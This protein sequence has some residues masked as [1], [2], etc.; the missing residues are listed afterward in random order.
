MEQLTAKL[1][2]SG[3][4]SYRGTAWLCSGQYALTAAHCVGDRER[5]V[6]DAGPFRLMFMNGEEVAA[7]LMEDN[8]DFNLDVAMLRITHGTLPDNVEI[9]CGRLPA[10]TPWPPRS[11]TW[12]AY[13]YPV[14]NESGMEL[15]GFI[16][17]PNGNVEG[18]PA[19]QLLC[20]QG[21]Y[22]ELEGT[23]GAA[24]R[25]GKIVVG[26]IRWAPTAFKQS[27]IYASPLHIIAEKL[28]V[29][30]NILAVNFKA[31]LAQLAPNLLSPR[32]INDTSA[33][34][35]IKRELIGRNTPHAAGASSHN[36][37]EQKT[38]FINRKELDEVTK[39]LSL[40]DVQLLTLVGLGGTG[41]TRLALEAG[42]ALV[43]HN[44]F[45]DGIFLVDMATVKDP[46][47]VAREIAN[48]LGIKEA[49][50]LSFVESLKLYLGDKQMLLIIDNFEQVLPAAPLF[51]ELLSVCKEL[52]VL[53]T[54]QQPLGVNGEEVLQIGPLVLP[55]EPPQGLSWQDLKEVA[56]VKLFEKRAQ[57][58]NKKFKL[59][60]QN[61]PLIAGI[62]RA[63]GGLPMAIE[64]VAA[65]AGAQVDLQKA[66]E[67]V[68]AATKGDAL[69]QT[70]KAVEFAYGKL[71]TEEQTLLRRLSLFVGSFNRMTA[72]HVFRDVIDS[73]EAVKQI[74][75]SL[76]RKCLLQEEWS[77]NQKVSYR[78]LQKI[79]D[80]CLNQLEASGEAA[81]ALRNHAR[82]FL[83]RA[84]RAEARMTVLTSQERKEWLNF[85]EKELD[86]IRAVLRWAFETEGG[87]G[88][89]LQ[90][91][92]SLFWFWNLRG[93]LTEGREHLVA[94]LKQTD[95]T[96]SASDRAKALYAA[97]GLA[98]LR[99]DFKEARDEL[100]ESVMLWRRVG[101]KRRLGYSLIILGM[102]ALHQGRPEEGREYEEESVRIFEEVD[103]PW[104]LALSLNDLGNVLNETG[105]T[106]QGQLHYERSL[107]LWRELDDKWGYSL[108][109]G[110]M[111][112]LALWNGNYIVAR[113][114]QL[115][116]LSIR[117][118]EGD[119]WGFAES[120]RRLGNV[121]ITQN[122]YVQAAKLHYDSLVLHQ[123]L[124]RKQLIAECLEDL[125]W[126]AVKLNQ[127]LRAAELFGAGEAI[128]GDTLSSLTP[129]KRKEYN[130][131]V[132]GARAQARATATFAEF[133]PAWER[134]SKL[135]IE[136]GVGRATQ[137][138]KEWT[139]SEG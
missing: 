69:D 14:G 19:Y 90:L 42:T 86:D 23:S 25:H 102:V 133:L 29:M 125:A 9:I 81:A 5:Q 85:L 135:S 64:I 63:L 80:Y 117:R 31:A 66:L 3:D 1:Y 50:N 98:F 34:P 110:N 54:S 16:T 51:T 120:L 89:G 79:K 106:E 11:E 136:Q 41:K 139:A 55:P 18:Q 103:D 75:D 10:Y 58:V 52:K 6:L 15:S 87:G 128:R 22:G 134:G 129:S 65:Q 83:Q 71:N 88:L 36:L 112:Q 137:Y 82:F 73:P 32:T 96:L 59:T 44:A 123:Q 67:K 46:E 127:T 131:R 84:K 7:E 20:D 38:A 21:G 93:Y 26:L 62:C 97:G 126:V 116:A 115:Q 33:R 94:A 48:T 91:A 60:T 12:S 92:A 57:E 100:E 95:E 56:A 4:E 68:A 61:A 76:S 53:I 111:G 8:C 28:P 121:F 30:E 17:S 113:E 138:V 43:Q 77:R 118:A 2:H 101:N 78:I 27:V 124:G 122:D 74:L 40:S 70:Q 104:G 132:E 24:V 72:E 35:T 108:T 99:G 130:E 49:Q 109:L 107:A 37:P 114:L 13:G 119:H 39:R 45:R 105:N 47:K